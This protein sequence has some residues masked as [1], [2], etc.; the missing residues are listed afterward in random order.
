MPYDQAK[1]LQAL[2]DYLEI[3]G[4]SDVKEL[5]YGSAKPPIYQEEFLVGSA[6]S[7]FWAFKAGETLEEFAPPSSTPMPQPS[8]FDSAFM[9]TDL[10]DRF[11]A[12]NKVHDALKRLNKRTF[13]FARPGLEPVLF[14]ARTIRLYADYSVAVCSG[15]DLPDLAPAFY[16]AFAKEMN[17]YDDSGYGWPYIENGLIVWDDKLTPADPDSYC[18]LDHETT[19]RLLGMGEVAVTQRYFENAERLIHLEQQ[20]ETKYWKMR[21]EKKAIRHDPIPDVHTKEAK[22]NFAKKRKGLE[23]SAADITAKKQKETH[24]EGAPDVTHEGPSMDMS[25]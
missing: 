6:M 12:F 21:Q 2:T 24:S 5:S 10:S 11:I 25:S 20:R 1:R 16:I 4:V 23:D 7:H 9:P 3:K 14:D 22:A 15:D 8:I 19:D 18:V 13:R 17:A